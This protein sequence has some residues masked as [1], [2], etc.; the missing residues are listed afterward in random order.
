MTRFSI[1]IEIFFFVFLVNFGCVDEITTI[2]AMLQVENV[3]IK[4]Y[5]GSNAIKAR[6]EKRKFEVEEGDLITSLNLYTAFKKNRDKGKSW[7]SRYFVNYKAMKRVEE[8]K[9]QM[10]RSLKRF[11][12]ENTSCEGMFYIIRF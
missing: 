2:L 3:F 5:S 11:D 8:I 12:I 6:I 1:G 7:C 10:L 4:P 9:S